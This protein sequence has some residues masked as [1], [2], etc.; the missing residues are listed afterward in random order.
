MTLLDMKKK[1]LTLVEELA[2]E[3]EL[4]TDDPD[5]AA[6]INDV[7]NQVMF[8]LARLKKIPKYVEMDVTKGDRITFEDI[9][10]ECGYE[11]YQIGIVRGVEY[12]PRADGTV[13]KILSDGTAEIDLY[14]YPERITDKT[15]DK[16]YEFELSPDVLEIMPYGVAGDLLKSDVSGEYGSIYSTRYETM[17]QALDPRYQMTSI[18]F[19]GGFSI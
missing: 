14:V 13:L 7:I 11:V 12:A 17:K 10:R 16:A 18:T 8:E 9:E 15:K 2:P 1:V 19:T 6:K 3:S 4:L 5:I